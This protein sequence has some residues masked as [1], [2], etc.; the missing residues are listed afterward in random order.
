M[1]KPKMVRCRYPKCKQMHETT[2]LKKEEAVQSGK[3]S[4]YHP[5]CYHTMQTINQIKDTF[6]KEI[7]PLMTSQQIGTLMATINNIVFMKGVDVDFLKFALDYYIQYKPGALKYPGGLHY[8]VQNADV[9][10][11]WNKQ[12]TQLIKAELK[13]EI[14]RHSEN[15]EL[16]DLMPG[17]PDVKQTYTP[18]SKSK[19]SNV[20]GA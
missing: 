14:E 13:S 11:A 12:Q 19:F 4:Y 9:Q 20:L 10:S 6:Y 18:K 5:D 3:S 8:I 16:N 2:E 1:D 17:I 15:V 7:N